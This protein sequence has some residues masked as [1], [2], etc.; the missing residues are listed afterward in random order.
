MI[1]VQCGAKDI[2][3]DS[4]SVYSELILYCDNAAKRIEKG[5]GKCPMKKGCNQVDWDYTKH[6][7]DSLP[8]GNMFK[9]RVKA[10]V[11]NAIRPEKCY[12]GNI[13]DNLFTGG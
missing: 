3:C 13:V 6:S 1:D 8:G 4:S 9:A 12:Y 10:C 7:W 2:A 5:L 11:N